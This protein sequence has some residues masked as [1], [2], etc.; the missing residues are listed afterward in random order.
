MPDDILSA[1]I[2]SLKKDRETIERAISLMEELLPSEPGEISNPT[3][4]KG[5]RGRRSMGVEERKQVSE[6]MR[7]YWRSQRS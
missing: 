5:R 6:R 3:A 1:L 4:A 2:L 7:R